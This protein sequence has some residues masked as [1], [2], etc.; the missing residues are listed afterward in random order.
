MKI[1]ETTKEAYWVSMVVSILIYFSIDF[2]VK[3]STENLDNLWQTNENNGFLCFSWFLIVFLQSSLSRKAR[4]KKLRKYMKKLRKNNDV[5]CVSCFVFHHSFVF[6]VK[7][8]R[9]QLWT[10]KKNKWKEWCSMRVL[11]FLRLFICFHC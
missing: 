11:F 4:K 6:L 7:K 8:G 5:L 2:I 10:S 1:F 3:K 9:E